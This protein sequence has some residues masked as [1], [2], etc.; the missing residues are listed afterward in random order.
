MYPVRSPVTQARSMTYSRVPSRA[1]L[2]LG[3]GS[4]VKLD[5]AGNQQIQPGIFS[6][7][8]ELQYDSD[9]QVVAYNT[10]TTANR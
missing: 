4:V 7:G 10:L 2:T 8:G 3:D 5:S 6:R 1:V 9:A